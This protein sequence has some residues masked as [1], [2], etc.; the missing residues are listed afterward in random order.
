MPLGHWTGVVALFEC[1]AST[2]PIR[3]DQVLAV[4]SFTKPQDVS[5]GVISLSASVIVN[6][7][8]PVVWIV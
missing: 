3:G 4:T 5:W 8:M 1:V 7:V 6:T 2:S